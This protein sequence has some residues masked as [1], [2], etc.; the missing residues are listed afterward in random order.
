[1]PTE[2]RTTELAGR[3]GLPLPDARLSELA[4][5]GMAHSPLQPSDFPEGADEME[6]GFE[7]VMRDMGWN[8]EGNYDDDDDDGLGLTEEEIL[9]AKQLMA[10]KKQKQ[11]SAATSAPSVPSVD[12]DDDDDTSSS[13]EDA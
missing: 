10:A 5:G 1:L 8:D 2:K 3:A 12:D 7:R 9:Q 6:M 4:S 11:Q 13:D